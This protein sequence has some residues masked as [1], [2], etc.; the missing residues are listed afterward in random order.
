[1]ERKMNVPSL[2]PEGAA[3]ATA[4]PSIPPVMKAA[5][6]CSK[7]CCIFCEVSRV[8]GAVLKYGMRSLEPS[9]GE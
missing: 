7:G 3:T 8:K 1:M 6:F 4:E 5:V 2:E 9:K